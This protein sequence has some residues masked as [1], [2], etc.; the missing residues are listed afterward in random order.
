VLLTFEGGEGAGKTTQL[1][2]LAAYLRE[3]GYLVTTTR[4]PGG[5]Q[6]GQQLRTLLLESATPLTPRA[7]AL[8]FAADSAQ[9]MA[10]VIKPALAQGHI[11]LCD[12]F[13][14]SMLAYQG[15]ANQNPIPDLVHLIAFATQG[16]RPTHTFVLDIDVHIG[17]KRA[18]Q[19]GALNRVEERGLRYHQLVR[20]GYL[21][22]AS[23]DESCTVLDASLSVEQ[24]H[25]E[26]RAV[27]DRLLEEFPAGPIGNR[28]TDALH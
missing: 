6:L 21:A 24:V 14:H 17:I 20:V 3:R 26:I 10:A 27:V 23:A 7:E 12:R 11:V 5:T 28:T 1:N 16:V 19:R 18:K 4:E 22:L 25:S 8:L 15:F 13:Y 2:L 9:H